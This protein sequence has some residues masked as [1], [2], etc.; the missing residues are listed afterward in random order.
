MKTGPKVSVVMSVYD[1]LPYVSTAVESIL[2]QTFEEF[3]FIIIDDGSTDGSTAVLRRYAA[4]DERIQLIVQ[5]NR[6]IPRAV[7][8]GLG[9]ASGAYIARMDAD[10][11]AL[12]ERFAKQVTYLDAHP[13]CVLLGG[14]ATAIDAEGKPFKQTDGPLSRGNANNAD[15]AYEHAELVNRMLQ[16]KWVFFNPSVMMR[17]RAV[18][19]TGG[20]DEHYSVAQDLDLFLRLAEVGKVANL[21]S[22]LIQYRCHEDQVSQSPKQ[23][24]LSNKARREAHV[25]RSLPLPK[26]LRMPAMIRSYGGMILRKANLWPTT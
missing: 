5:E 1:G 14:E 26:D 23:R 7:N 22:P 12:P 15:L 4:Q 3:E 18:E 17:R 2:E 8:R 16:G 10:D 9:Q 20:Y 19:A 13:E 6:G 25:R 24:Y 21:E 11:I